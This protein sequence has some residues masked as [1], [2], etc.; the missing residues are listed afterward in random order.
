MARGNKN[1]HAV[2]RATGWNYTRSLRFVKDVQRSNEAG[3]FM[4]EQGISK[5]EAFVAIAK[6]HAELDEEE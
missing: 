4:K 1:A 3:R 5:R 6:A 2:K